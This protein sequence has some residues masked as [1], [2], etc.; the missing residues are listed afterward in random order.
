M[1]LVAKGR[2]GL[3]AHLREVYLLPSSRIV[4]KCG[5]M[6]RNDIEFD[7]ATDKVADLV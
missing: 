4:S 7:R 2:L 5:M 1:F 6:A 3:I